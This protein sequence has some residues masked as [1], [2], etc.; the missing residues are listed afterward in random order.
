M[1]N[2]NFKY[3]VPILKVARI[4]D[5][6]EVPFQFTGCYNGAQ[7]NFD[8]CEGDVVCHEG[9]YGHTRGEVETY[10]FPWDDGDVSVLSHSECAKKI[11]EYYKQTLD[12]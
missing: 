10:Q 3:L 7:L 6:L 1:M 8:W 12:N 2:T 9:S 4:L 11:I 5:T